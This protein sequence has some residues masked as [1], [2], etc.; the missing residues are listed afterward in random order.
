MAIFSLND[1]LNCIFLFYGTSL[2]YIKLELALKNRITCEKMK[3]LC[4]Y[5]LWGCLSVAAW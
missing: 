2:H 3:F 1:L 5:L 4:C